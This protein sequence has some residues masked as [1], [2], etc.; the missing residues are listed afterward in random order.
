MKKHIQYYLEYFLVKFWLIITKLLGLEISTLLTS[1]LFRTIG[2]YLKPTRIARHNLKMVLPDLNPEEIIPQVWDNL[3]RMAA[4]TSILVDMETSKF[5]HYVKVTGS[6]N[7]KNLIGKKALFF[8]AHLA[9]WEIIGKA[10]LPYDIQFHAVYRAANNKLFDDTLNDIRKKS[11][12]TLIPKGKTG[13][14]KIIKALQN[15]KHVV[16]LLDQKMNDGVKLD[17]M[18][19]EAM[20]APAIASLALKY[21]CPIIP[22]QSIRKNGSFFEIII[23]PEIHHKNRSI[24]EIMT[25]INNQIGGWVKANPGQW[26]WLHRR[27]I[28]SK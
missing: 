14:K 26:L 23:H 10:L 5:N 18:G 20:T 4:E 16:M 27:W 9:N 19:H 22:M 1:K 2:A 11:K 6:D 21:D 17:F 8:T 7:L 28:D 13:A 3:G 24:E 15:D 25:Q 12:A